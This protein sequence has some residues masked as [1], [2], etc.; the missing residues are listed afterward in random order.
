[1]ITNNETFKREYDNK[2]DL[3]EKLAKEMV[4][5]LNELLNLDEIKL[6]FPIE[7][8]VKSWDSIYNKCLRNQL[9]TKMLSEINDITGIRIIVLF[10]RDLEKV[11][12]IVSG[13]FDVHRTEDTSERLS[14]NQFGYGS[15]HYEVTPKKSWCE[16][17][18][19]SRL[20]GLKAE[21][22]VRTA[23]QHIWAA[24]SHILQYK[25]ESHV[26]IPLRRSINRVSALLE[27]VDLEFERVLEERQEYVGEV[28]SRT[29]GILNIDKLSII[30]DKM[31]PCKNKEDNEEYS[32]LLDDLN[33]FGI[34]SEEQLSSLIN[35]YLSVIINK[36]RQAVEEIAMDP[37]TKYIC[38]DPNRLE[39]GVF[40]TY[41]GLVR[42]ALE[43]EFGDQYR[44]HLEF[45]KSPV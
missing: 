44:Q 36:D 11:C 10:H 1:M 17:P 13:N 43:E 8:R 37:E 30:L 40:Y 26:P 18:T 32:K 24:A 38:D 3:Y 2:R 28:S 27:T 35:K 29:I 34:S 39:R 45:K 22:Q 14:E 19:L 23:S 20:N 41:V 21:I 4:V 31:L 33:K 5:Q 16:L 12:K 42:C 9:N 15:I 7:W 6:A 25:R